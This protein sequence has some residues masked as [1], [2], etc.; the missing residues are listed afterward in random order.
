MPTEV[1]VTRADDGLT[2]AVIR[3][4]LDLAAAPAVQRQ[5]LDATPAAGMALLIDLAEVDAVDAAGVGALLAAV[6]HVRANGGE[7]V[8]VD[9]SEAVF[10]V[11]RL[12]RLESALDIAPNV[13]EAR[14]RFV[15]SGSTPR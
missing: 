5:L 10:R 11:L 2:V 15:T 14:G 4:A 6:L 13:T 1:D 7:V 8:L 3:G 9:P 12:G